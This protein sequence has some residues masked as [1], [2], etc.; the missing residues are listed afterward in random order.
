[1]IISEAIAWAERRLKDCGVESARLDAE[2]LLAHALGTQRTELYA[3]MREP[4][5]ADA[6]ARFSS[7]VKRRS[8]GCPVAYITGVKE[9]WSIP[10][11]V[12]PDVL[13]PR[14]ETET[15]VEEA[16]RVAREIGATRILDLCTGSGCIAAA[17]AKELAEAQF[18]VADSSPAAIEVAKR[19]LSFAISRVEFLLGDLFDPTSGPF[20]AITANPPYIDEEGMGALPRDIADHEPRGALAAGPDGLDFTWRIINDA[21]DHL[22]P[23]GW[24]VMEVGAGQAPA[25]ISLATAQDGY[26]TI[27]TARDLAGIERVVILRRSP[28]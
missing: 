5:P 24:L 28:L 16:L 27:R 13:I 15:V 14:P 21:P 19:N 20:D 26:D 12:T 3:R 1:M 10:I 11:E 22:V 25:C 2:V 23:G 8:S 7:S 18:S 6:A 9:F 17:M 4:L